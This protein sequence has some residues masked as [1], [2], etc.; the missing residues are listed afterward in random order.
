MLAIIVCSFY[1]AVYSVFMCGAVDGR[2]KGRT[3]CDVELKYG[4]CHG[5]ADMVFMIV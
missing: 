1:T 3:F 2:K 5:R 4:G